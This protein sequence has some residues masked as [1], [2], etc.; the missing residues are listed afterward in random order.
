MGTSRL[1]FLFIVCFV[2]FFF[3][4]S[5]EAAQEQLDQS[6]IETLM[7]MNLKD[8][9]EVEITSASKRSQKI[10]ESPSP[11]YVFTAEDIQRTGVRNIMELVKYIPG[12][13]VYP[14]I[15]QPFVIANR[16]IR[17]SS[18]DKILF[19]LDGIPLN[20]ISKSGAVNADKFPG[21]DMVKR[22]EVIPGPGSTMWGSDA[23]LGIISIITKDGNDIDGNIINVDMATKDNHRQANLLSGKRF[24]DGEYILSL[25]YAQ[26]DGFGVEQNGYKNFVF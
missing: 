23:S 19:L 26:S 24:S 21:L 7:A 12:F 4:Q 18:N 5:L 20:N 16:G 10:N 25:T 2:F 8:L 14:R 22:V 9:M 1:F 6:R 15:D 11:I 17:S 13:Y 3:R